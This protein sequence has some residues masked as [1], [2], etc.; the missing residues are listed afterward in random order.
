MFDRFD[1]NIN[2]R[3]YCLLSHRVQSQVVNIVFDFGLDVKYLVLGLGFRADGH[4]HGVLY[5]S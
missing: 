3:G 5:R 4:N 1:A 2:D